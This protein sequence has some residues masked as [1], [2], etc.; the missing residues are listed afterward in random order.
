MAIDIGKISALEEIADRIAI[1]DVLH[2]HSRGLDRGDVACIRACYWPDAEVDYGSFKG[3]AHVFAEAVVPALTAAYELTH[4]AVTN[5]LVHFFMHQAR[6]E[7]YVT[8]SHLMIG[9]KR[10]MIFSGRYL[11][12]LV[13]HGDQWKLQHRL[14]VMD[15]S[16]ERKLSDA[17][18]SESFVDLH[19]GSNGMEDPLYDFLGI[20]G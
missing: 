15:W 6:T 4:H 11:D 8:A 2:N 13:R 10:E 9:A 12:T 14:V 5:T 16:R 19:K 20:G 7:S 17:R 18:E 1:Q 3:S